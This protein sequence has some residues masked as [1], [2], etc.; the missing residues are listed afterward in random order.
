MARI[1]PLGLATYTI[2]ESS[3]ANSLSSVDLYQF[4]GD[5]AIEYV[6]FT[7]FSVGIVFT[8]SISRI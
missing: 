4:V 7:C 3:T 2:E 5:V 1:P 8:N 6:L